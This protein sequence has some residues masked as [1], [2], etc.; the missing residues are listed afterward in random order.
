[1]PRSMLIAN[2][3]PLWNWSRPAVS[4]LKIG[5]VKNSTLNIGSVLVGIRDITEQPNLFALKAAIEAARAGEQGRGSVVLVDEVRRLASRTQQSTQEIH[6]I[7]ARL[8]SGVS[9][10]VGAMEQGA[11]VLKRPWSRPVRR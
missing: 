1:M 5:V 7:I 4:P 6:D 2:P 9:R 10:A 11:N 8:Q 3:G